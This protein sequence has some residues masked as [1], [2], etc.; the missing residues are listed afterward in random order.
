MPT[1]H[2]PFRLA[3]PERF[4]AGAKSDAV[5]PGSPRQTR[6]NTTLTSVALKPSWHRQRMD[7][8]AE[9]PVFRVGAWELVMDYERKHDGYI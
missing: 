3:P 1:N 6:L 2:R 5:P 4:R 7:R 8:W 9:Q